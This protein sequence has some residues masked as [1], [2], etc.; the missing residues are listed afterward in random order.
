VEARAKLPEGRAHGR[1]LDAVH[2]Q[3]YGSWPASGE[4]DIMEYVGWDHLRLRQAYSRISGD[5]R[6]VHF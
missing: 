1:H 4:I 5:Y 3:S 2:D 6:N